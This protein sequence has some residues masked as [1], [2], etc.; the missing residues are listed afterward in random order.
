MFVSR[1]CSHFQII[2]E[3][4]HLESMAC[5]SNALVLSCRQS[6]RNFIAEVFPVWQVWQDE[7][8]GRGKYFRQLITFDGKPT[9]PGE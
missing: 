9:I 6:P 3:K 5:H 2:F 7:F 1:H 8:G 4:D